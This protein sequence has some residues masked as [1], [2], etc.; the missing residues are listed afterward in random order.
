MLFKKSDCKRASVGMVLTVGALAVVGAMSVVKC[1]KDM[2]GCAC[3]KA[4]LVMHNM[5]H[6]KECEKCE[7]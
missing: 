1:G 4:S 2:M 3:K 7:E 5:M 6:R